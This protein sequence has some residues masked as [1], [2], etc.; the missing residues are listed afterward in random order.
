MDGWYDDVFFLNEKEGWLSDKRSA[1]FYHTLDSGQSWIP[2]T[3]PEGGANVVSTHFVSAEEGWILVAALGMDNQ[4]IFYTK[5]GSKSW[6]KITAP[7]VIGNIP[8]RWKRGSLYKI[9]FLNSLKIKN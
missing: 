8:K 9:L 5:D 1:K 6:K 2:V 3:L 4:G 7:E